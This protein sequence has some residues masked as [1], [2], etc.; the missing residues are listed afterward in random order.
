MIL[1]AAAISDPTYEIQTWHVYLLLLALLIFEGFLTMNSTKFIGYLNL[2]GTIAN[3]VVLIIFVIWLPAGSI[4]H[5]K[6]NDSHYV[7]TEIVNGTEW[8]TGFGFLMGFLSV[9]WTIG[10]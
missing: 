2:V 10:K 6:T 9:I 8:P 4:N 1:T 3:V 7:W 5:P